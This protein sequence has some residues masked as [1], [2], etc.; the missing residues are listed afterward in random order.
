MLVLVYWDLPNCTF[1]CEQ[2][3]VN[4]THWTQFVGSL[5]RWRGFGGRQTNA[6]AVY[7]CLAD[8]VTAFACLP[9]GC[10]LFALIQISC[11]V[12]FFEQK[13][14]KPEQKMIKSI[15]GVKPLHPYL[16]WISLKSEQNKW[17]FE[18]K[19]LFWIMFSGCLCPIYSPTAVVRW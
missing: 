11:F 2:E 9:H 13:T 14:N 7:T 19:Y 5:K 6:V 3:L 18:I 8:T 10:L 17:S 16:A 12:L 4:I 1:T 15:N